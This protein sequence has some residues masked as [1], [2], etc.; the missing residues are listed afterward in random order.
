MHRLRL[1]SDKAHRSEI[2]SYSTALLRE[3]HVYGLAI[4]LGN[5]HDDAWQH[6]GVGTKLLGAAEELALE[7]GRDRI[8]CMSGIVRWFQ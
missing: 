1:P 4:N 6:R 3:L 7:N 5:T 8:V 2:H